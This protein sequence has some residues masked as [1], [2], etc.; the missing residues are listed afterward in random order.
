MTEKEHQREY[1]GCRICFDY[2]LSRQKNDDGTRH[3]VI[4]VE[5]QAGYEP[6]TFDIGSTD[7]TA[8]W[9][10]DRANAALARTKA[11]VNEIISSTM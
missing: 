7:E 2:K 4:V 6:T 5:D 8:L 1:P 9:N 10:V 3:P 11:D